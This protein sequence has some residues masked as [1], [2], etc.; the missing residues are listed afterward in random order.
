MGDI[1][2]EVNTTDLQLSNIGFIAKLESIQAKFKNGSLRA[3]SLINYN[4]NNKF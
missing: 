2:P 4:N 3:P 1:V